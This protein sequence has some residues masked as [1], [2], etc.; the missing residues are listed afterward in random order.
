M[1]GPISNQHRIQWEMGHQHVGGP[2]GAGEGE[3]IAR[4][5]CGTGIAADQ[6][7]LGSLTGLMVSESP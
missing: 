2:G 7:H 5:K 3:P 6:S 1:E 4:F